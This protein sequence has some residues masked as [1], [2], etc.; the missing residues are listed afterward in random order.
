MSKVSKFTMIGFIILLGVSAVIFMTLYKDSQEK[1][2]DLKSRYQMKNDSGFIYILK[3]T[4]S[5]IPLAETLE[6]ISNTEKDE[7]PAKVQQLIEAAKIEADQIDEQMWTLIEFSDDYSEN[8]DPEIVV[9]SAVMTSDEQYD[10]YTAFSGT[11]G[12]VRT[13]SYRYWKSS[14]KL[15]D[16]GTREY[17]RSLAGELRSMDEILS[18]I[19]EEYTTSINSLYDAKIAKANLL[20]LIKPHLIKIDKLQEVFYSN[21]ENF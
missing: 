6:A 7:S 18:I 20:G 8:R 17:L 5:L 16:E 11:W 13:I 9:N 1:Y 10:M 19:K 15:I 21:S 12:S 3:N 4:V 14:P 2:N